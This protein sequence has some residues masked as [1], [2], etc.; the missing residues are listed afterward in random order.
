MPSIDA[1]FEMA[2]RSS[3]LDGRGNLRELFGDKTADCSKAEPGLEKKMLEARDDWF[4]NSIHAV[5]LQD[6]GWFSMYFSEDPFDDVLVKTSYVQNW[7]GDK[8]MY[9]EEMFDKSHAGLGWWHM[10]AWTIEGAED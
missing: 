6:V 2:G 10:P 1:E 4:L 7:I 9:D 8:E 5:L 3:C